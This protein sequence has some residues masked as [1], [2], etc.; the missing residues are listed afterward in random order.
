[1]KKL[2]PGLKDRVKIIA[3]DLEGVI[4]EIMYCFKGTRYL[5]R[6]FFNGDLKST[7]LYDFEFKVMGAV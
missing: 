2:E 6:Y 5:V 1:M 4:S 7:W 3:L